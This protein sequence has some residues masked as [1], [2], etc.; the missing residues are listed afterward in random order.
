MNKTL[1]VALSCLLALAAVPACAANWV[2]LGTDARGNTWHFDADSVLHEH[3]TV[4]AWKRIEFRQPY[5][6]FRKGTPL[7]SAFV[8]NVIDCAEQRTDLKA[9]GL[10]DPQGS[11]IAVHESASRD[12]PWPSTIQL[13]LLEHAVAQICAHG[14]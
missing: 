10:L 7:K 2:S 6:H 5:P 8:L 11:V 14:K 9:I 3:G 12:T 13:P 1:A 4:T